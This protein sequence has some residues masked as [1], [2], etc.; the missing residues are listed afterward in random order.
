MAIL[1]CII[2][3]F[4]RDSLGPV[5]NLYCFSNTLPERLNFQ[6]FILWLIRTILFA[7]ACVFGREW[8][9]HPKNRLHSRRTSG[10]YSC[11]SRV[12]LRILLYSFLV[13]V[14]VLRHRWMHI[15][16]YIT[17]TESGNG[18]HNRQ[19]SRGGRTS[20]YSEISRLTQLQ[21]SVRMEKYQQRVCRRRS[22]HSLCTQYITSPRS[23]L[24]PKYQCWGG[25]DEKWLKWWCDARDERHTASWTPQNWINWWTATEI[26]WERYPYIK[27]ILSQS[28]RCQSWECNSFIVLCIPE[29]LCKLRENDFL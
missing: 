18:R 2:H 29:K 11:G 10:T 26:L 24:F 13:V 7:A 28:A 12:D 1:Q 23:I 9:I 16:L 8:G 6:L 27:G 15:P 25:E 22:I 5:G 14:C 17:Q 19:I 4:G 20:S 21:T 3:P